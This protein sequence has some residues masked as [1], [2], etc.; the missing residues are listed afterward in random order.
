MNY[1]NKYDLDPIV[2]KWLE[3]DDYDYIPGVLSATTLMRP[4]RITGSYSFMRPG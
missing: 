4:T 1:T 3:A 2:C